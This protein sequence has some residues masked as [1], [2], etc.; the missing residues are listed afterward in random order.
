MSSVAGHHIPVL[1][2]E[3]M[4][5]LNFD[6]TYYIDITQVF[7]LKIKAISCHISQ[8][9]S[10]FIDLIKLMNSYRSAQCNS[11]VGTY[12]ECY[13]FKKSFPFLDITNILP[14]SPTLKPF[15]I[16]DQLGFL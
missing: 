8:K 15:D 6:P 11:P 3:T 9:P 7:E 13:Y 10:R 16:E 5:G 2:S 4:M 1:Y 12:A 14:P